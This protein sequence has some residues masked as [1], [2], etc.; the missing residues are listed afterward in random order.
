MHL[1]IWVL[2]NLKPLP[3]IFKAQTGNGPKVGDQ[4]TD[5]RD[6][7]NADTK[8]STNFS[9]I[10]SFMTGKG[11]KSSADSDVTQA[12]YA[13]RPTTRDSRRYSCRV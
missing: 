3:S 13:T 2:I 11:R 6:E 9:A 10:R 7:G 4:D 12:V 8:S 5:N 1:I